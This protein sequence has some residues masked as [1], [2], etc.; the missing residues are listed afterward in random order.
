MFFLKYKKFKKWLFASKAHAFW[1]IFLLSAVVRALPELVRV[2][3]PQKIYAID[4]D[5]SVYYVAAKMMLNGIMPY[6]DFTLL[7]P[8]ATV[9]YMVP[10][11][12]LSNFVSDYTALTIANFSVMILVSLAIGFLTFTMFKHSKKSK[13]EAIAAGIA[14]SAF[15]ILVFIERNAVQE[16]VINVLTVL[17]L[18]CFIKIIKYKQHPF[19]Y[20][21]LSFALA[22]GLSIKILAITNVAVI[23]IVLFVLKRYKDLIK[24]TVIGLVFLVIINIHLILYSPTNAFNMIIRTQFGRAKNKSLCDYVLF[25][26]PYST[27]QM[28]FIFVFFCLIVF[29]VSR[30]F[31]RYEQTPRNI[32]IYTAT[33]GFLINALLIISANDSIF[34]YY[35]VLA[36]WGAVLA[37]YIYVYWRKRRWVKRTLWGV[38]AVSLAFSLVVECNSTFDGSRT[39]NLKN[40]RADAAT[41]RCVWSNYMSLQVALNNIDTLIQRQCQFTVDPYGTLLEDFVGVPYPENGERRGGVGDSTKIFSGE[42]ASS[43]KLVITNAVNRLVGDVFM[44]D[45]NLRFRLY[46]KYG[47][48]EIW[49]KI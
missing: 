11:A 1:F 19:T 27:R 13:R 5:P 15:P 24:I 41:T 39:V 37:G 42:I 32:I 12:W 49:V 17:A 22:L 8:P 23:F 7:H 38:V 20:V 47:M 29:L 18:Y 9:Y 6:R 35:D 33:L 40:L 46:K 3:L 26:L 34:H 28:V 21:L 43:D 2:F 48:V 14:W 31:L 36:V 44:T 45:Q 16:A 4:D 25:F 10:F 30:K